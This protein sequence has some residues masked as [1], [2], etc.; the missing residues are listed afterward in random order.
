MVSDGS[1]TPSTYMANEVPP[2]QVIT[3]WCTL[4]SFTTSEPTTEVLLASVVD[5]TQLNTPAAVIPSIFAVDVVLLM[6]LVTAE[7]IVDVIQNCT[8][9][10]PV[11]VSVDDSVPTVFP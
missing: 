7:S 3:T 1:A 9:Q 2:L 5:V 10:L 4:P 11:A 6:C 8:D